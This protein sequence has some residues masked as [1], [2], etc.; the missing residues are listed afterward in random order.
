MTDESKTPPDAA[1]ADSGP[2]SGL[3]KSIANLVATVVAIAQTRLE[4]LTTD[5]QEEM[6]RVAEILVWTLIALLAALIGLFLAA[7]AV[8]FVFWDTHRLLAAVLV[9][10]A[11]FVIAIAASV[12]L[13][14]KIRTKPRMLDATLAELAKDREQLAGRR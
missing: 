10:S 7:L 2:V 9:T 4:L 6:H 12:V 13:R 3:F 1:A 14:V 5:L 8:I 11:F